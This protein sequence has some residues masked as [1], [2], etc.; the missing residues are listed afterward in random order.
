MFRSLH[1]MMMFPQAFSNSTRLLF[2]FFLRSQSSES[3]FCQPEKFGKRN[4]RINKVISTFLMFR[5]LHFTK[6][7]GTH[8]ILLSS[9]FKKL[10]SFR[11]EFKLRRSRGNWSP[12]KSCTGCNEFTPRNLILRLIC[13]IN[14]QPT[15]FAQP[16]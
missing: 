15:K 7:D 5:S 10:H 6:S 13:F 11:P 16:Y 1:L 8:S 3:V 12:P 14:P 4:P 2:R 9:F